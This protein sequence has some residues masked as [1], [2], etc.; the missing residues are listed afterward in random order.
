MAH[1][2]KHFGDQDVFFISAY[3]YIHIW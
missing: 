3:C 2:R 1:N